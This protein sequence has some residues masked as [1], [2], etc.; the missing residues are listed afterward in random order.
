[1]TTD[2]CVGIDISGGVACRARVG[3]SG[4]V[5]SLTTKDGGMVKG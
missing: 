2:A 1:M 4:D 3:K 5:L